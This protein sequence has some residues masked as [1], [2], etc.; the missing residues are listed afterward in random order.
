MKEGEDVG[1]AKKHGRLW[2]VLVFRSNSGARLDRQANAD[3]SRTI[4]RDNK[5]PRP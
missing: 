1:G 3:P 2:A 4:K 5:E